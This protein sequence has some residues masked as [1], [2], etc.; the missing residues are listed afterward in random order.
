MWDERRI[1]FTLDVVE[2]RTFAG[3]VGNNIVALIQYY[4]DDCDVPPSKI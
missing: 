2:R 4:Y 3:S 1:I